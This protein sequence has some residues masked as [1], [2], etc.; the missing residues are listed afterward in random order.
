MKSTASFSD[1][2]TNIFYSERNDNEIVLFFLVDPFDDAS[3]GDDQA[4][5]VDD[6]HVRIQQRN[7]RKVL[8]TIQGIDENY[9]KKKLVKAF[10]K[11]FL[12][13]LKPSS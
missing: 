3:K 9:D 1:V 7:G 13:S 11:V 4:A 8:T 2:V 6:V 5:Q 10:K 12:Y